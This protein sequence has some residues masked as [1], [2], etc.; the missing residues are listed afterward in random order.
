MFKFLNITQFLFQ[1]FSTME[2]DENKDAG[3]IPSF[4]RKKDALWYA[5]LEAKSDNK[6]IPYGFT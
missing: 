4:E 5:K 6:R 2:N 1:F 3:V